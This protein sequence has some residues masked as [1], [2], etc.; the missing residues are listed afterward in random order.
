M[1]GAGVNLAS[2]VAISPNGAAVSTLTNPDGT[3]RIDGLP[4]RSY[5]V[6]VHP[7]PPAQQ[8]QATP[9]DIVFFRGRGQT[10]AGARSSPFLTVFYPSTNTW[11]CIDEYP[12]APDR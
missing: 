1:S 5:Y 3:Y 12:R 9:G 7:L 6:Y 2:V 8:G 10:T 4:P 11:A